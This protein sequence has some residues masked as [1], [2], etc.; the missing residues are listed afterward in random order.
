MCTDKDVERMGVSGPKLISSTAVLSTDTEP[1]ERG[2]VDGYTSH[3]PE[4]CKSSDLLK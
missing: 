4:N 3:F 1:T 2:G